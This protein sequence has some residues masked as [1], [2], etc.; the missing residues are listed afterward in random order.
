NGGGPPSHVAGLQ[1]VF[2]PVF[3]AGG[4]AIYGAT[5]GPDVRRVPVSPDTARATGPATAMVVPG[6]ANVRHV[7][8]ARDGEH[9]AFTGMDLVS[10]LWTLPMSGDVAA[11]AP[12]PLTDDRG[13]RQTE[14]A[15]SPDG[16]ALAFWS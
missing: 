6:I 3:A 7:S 8:M 11:G 15:F 2:D 1:G 4:A 14:P 9:M 16:K 10:H 12:A 13:V 5:G